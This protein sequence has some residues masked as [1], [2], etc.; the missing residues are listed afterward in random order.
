MTKKPRAPLAGLFCT[1]PRARKPIYTS[2]IHPNGG[3]PPNHRIPEKLEKLEFVTPRLRP[4]A[5]ALPSSQGFQLYILFSFF[6]FN[7]TRESTPGGGMMN[8]R[9]STVL[10]IR[11]HSLAVSGAWRQ[12]EGWSPE[13]ADPVKYNWP[14]E[15]PLAHWGQ[16]VSRL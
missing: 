4:P 3:I 8:S 1:H 7:A 5:L 11:R 6:F 9:I 14:R 13:W 16:F 2:P 12:A 10:M 15:S